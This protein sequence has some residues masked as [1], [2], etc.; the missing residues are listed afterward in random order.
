MIG[1][2]RRVPVFPN[3]YFER[4]RTDGKILISRNREIIVA[5]ILS[6]AFTQRGIKADSL[7]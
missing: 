6:R 3:P 5:H 4:L 1:L 7:S 2:A